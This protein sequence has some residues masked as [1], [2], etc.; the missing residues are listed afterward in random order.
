MKIIGE[1][2]E[3]T[4]TVPERRRSLQLSMAVSGTQQEDDQVDMEIDDS[5]PA[6]QLSPARSPS[7]H[8]ADFL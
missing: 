2:L 6:V 4:P 7:P 3:S 5:G 1:S 8:I